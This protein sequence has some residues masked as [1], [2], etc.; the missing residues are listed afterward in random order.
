MY[1]SITTITTVG[2]GDIS[3]G[4]STERVYALVVM[5]LG[6]FIYSYT[7]GALSNLMTNLDAR[8]AKLNR[9]LEL[10]GE[11][12]LE[13]GISKDFHQ[14]LATALEYD[15]HKNRQDFDEISEC[16]PLNL[17]NQLRIVVYRNILDSN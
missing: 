9:K 2:Y 14:K 17:R 4:N 15:H 8:K 7:I 13:Y 3:A 11:L 16:L 12:S 10:L 1:W 5:V 6:V